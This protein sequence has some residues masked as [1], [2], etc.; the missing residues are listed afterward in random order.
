MIL[1]L[2]NICGNMV[3][4]AVRPGKIILALIPTITVWHVLRPRHD[5]CMMED[6]KSERIPI[7]R[8]CGH[9]PPEEN[10]DDIPDSPEEK[11]DLDDDGKDPDEDPI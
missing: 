9:Q 7:C 1:L 4:S 5:L 6:W 11:Q 10:R 2:G 8:A 3:V